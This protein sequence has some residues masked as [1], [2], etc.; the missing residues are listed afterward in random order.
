MEMNKQ[1][2]MLFTCLVILRGKAD[3]K[4][5]ELPLEE[6]YKMLERECCDTIGTFWDLVDENKKLKEI[7]E[8]SIYMP[9][10]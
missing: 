2:E 5:K 9:Q 6:L 8:N 3:N 4:L 7:I 1:K 10:I